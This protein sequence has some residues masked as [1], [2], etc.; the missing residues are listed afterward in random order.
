MLA[1]GSEKGAVCSKIRIGP[2]F[3]EAQAKAFD[4]LHEQM[5][6]VVQAFVLYGK[7]APGSVVRMPPEVGLWHRERD[8][9]PIRRAASTHSISAC[10]L[11]LH[12]FTFP[13]SPIIAKSSTASNAFVRGPRF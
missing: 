7:L 1:R 2:H 10:A 11:G 13:Q 12:Y 4:V 8:A 5:Q 9:S 3:S 6:R